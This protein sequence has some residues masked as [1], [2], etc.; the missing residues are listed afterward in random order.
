MEL[1]DEMLRR[2]RDIVGDERVLADSY[3]VQLFSYDASVDAA[4]AQVVVIPSSLDELQQVV[5]V[6]HH[7][8]IPLVPRGGGTGLSGAAI[9]CEGGLV[10]S[11]GRLRMVLA[12]QPNDLAAR[13][14][15]GVINLHLSRA[16]APYHLHYAPDPSSQAASTIG[17]NI[18]M[19]AGGPH[20]LAYGVTANHILGVDLCLETGEWMPIG[21]LAPDQPGYDLLSV[22]VGSEGTLGVVGTA[23]TRL[24]PTA[25][26]VRTLVAVFGE[27]AAAASCIG[28]IIRAGIV[29]TALEMMDN[30]T[31]RA[32][33]PSAQAGYPLDAAAV[34]LIECEGLTEAVETA[35][36]AIAV[37][38]TQYGALSVHLA[39]NAD[40]RARLWKA[41]KEAGGAYGRLAPNYYVM[42]GVVPRGSLP[43]V[44]PEIERIAQRHNLRVATLLHAGDGNLHP[45]LLFDS[46]VPGEIERVLAAGVDIID[47]CIRHGGSLTGEH[48]IG[49]EKLDVVGLMYSADDQ[50]IMHRVREVF[51]PQHRCNPGKMLPQPGRCI[52]LRGRP[53]VDA[54]W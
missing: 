8:G 43:V 39:A 1:S 18:A 17:G 40:E 3:S 52:E 49:M 48:G 28:A 34:L 5:R 7:Y 33:E 38:C 13:V 45:A 31:I 11:F 54:R 22:V 21:G 36:E 15:A 46:E 29:P 42:D 53:L 12:V 20:T 37:L 14:Q 9:P 25:E 10:L 47:L 6:A 19:N 26:D 50:L 27:I 30:A 4:A 24:V 35:N 16:A 2:L 51:D 44:L 23:I 41:R 32:V